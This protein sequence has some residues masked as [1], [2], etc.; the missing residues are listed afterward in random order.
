MP[1]MKPL[2]PGLSP[3]VSAALG[4]N[5]VEVIDLKSGKRVNGISGLSEPQGVLYLPDD[6]RLYV[7]SGKDGTLR[8]FAEG[9]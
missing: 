5:S 6:D 7:A 9:R 3:Y 4:N 1:C 2:Q 8:V